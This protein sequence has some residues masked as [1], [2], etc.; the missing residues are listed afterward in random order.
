[1]RRKLIKVGVVAALTA[2]GVIHSWPPSLVASFPAPSGA[3]DVAFEEWGPLFVLVPGTPSRVYE[4]TTLGSVVGSF[5]VAVPNGARGLTFRR[6]P[7]MRMWVGNRL[8]G[9]IYAMTT[10]GSLISS[11]LCP[12]GKPYG[13]G[14][15]MYNPTHGSGLYASCRDENLIVRMDQTTGSLLSSF[16]GP[17]S[18]VIGYDD[19]LCV[20]RDSNYIYW[21]YYR[22]WRILATLPV[23]PYGVGTGVLWP[24]DQLVHGFV[25]GRNGYIYYYRGYSAVAPASLGR[26]KALFR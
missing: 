11:F 14:F 22:D 1:M 26:V 9:Y 6:Y 15:S 25:L 4:L 18:A 13:L 23:R 3:R 16:A 5:N 8:N 19:W 17:G 7:D 12:G 24:T 21:D 20:D 2:V 10:S